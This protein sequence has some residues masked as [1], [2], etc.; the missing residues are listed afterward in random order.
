VARLK[1]GGAKMGRLPRIK[2]SSDQDV[3]YHLYSRVSGVKGYYPLAEDSAQKYLY[4]RLKFYAGIY[5]MEV[6][7]FSFM[8]NHYHLVVEFKKFEVLSLE[9]LK[10][11]ASKLYV[12]NPKVTKEWDEAQWERFN[13]RIYDV[14]EFMRN[15]QMGFSKWYNKTYQRK[16]RLWG[17]R[18]KST[19]LEDIKS[20]RDALFYVELN[21]V[22]AAIVER[23]EDYKGGSM[24]YRQMG[25]DLRMMSLEKIMLC[26]DIKQ[27]LRDYRASVYYRGSVRSKTGQAEIPEHIIRQEEAAGSEVQGVYLKRARYFAEGVVLG[28]EEFVK[29]FTDRLKARGKYLKKRSAAAVK[30]TAHKAL[31]LQRKTAFFIG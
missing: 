3:F 19:L 6:A 30:K 1:H 26:K 11:I 8:G 23:P 16:E 29:S 24:F 20:A 2:A 15:V 7:G 28:S 5:K 14:S 31:K 9:E 21:A 13:N 17:D 12:K 18:F 27:A 4:S 10:K 25:A 22:R